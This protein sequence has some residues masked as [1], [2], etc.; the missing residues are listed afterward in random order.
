MLAFISRQ[1]DAASWRCIKHCLVKEAPCVV[2]HLDGGVVASQ[3]DPVFANALGTLDPSQ[4]AVVHNHFIDLVVT[5]EEVLISDG[6]IGGSVAVESI[7][8]SGP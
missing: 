1:Q 8:A 2:D 4:P 3:N 6:I 5:Y 7:G